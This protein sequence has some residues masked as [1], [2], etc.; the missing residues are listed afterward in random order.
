MCALWGSA[1]HLQDLQAAPAPRSPLLLFNSSM[2]RCSSR[3]MGSSKGGQ[4]Q[5]QQP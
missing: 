4:Q 2:C 5:Q 3:H 1:A